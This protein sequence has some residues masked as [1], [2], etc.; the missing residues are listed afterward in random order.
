MR[1]KILIGVIILS[2]IIWGT[3]GYQATWPSQLETTP[4]A[5]WET[6]KYHK[7]GIEF[8][9]PKGLEIVATRRPAEGCDM[10][11][12]FDVLTLNYI[13]PHR[14]LA[15]IQDGIDCVGFGPFRLISNSKLPNTQ[16]EKFIGV[17]SQN[18]N[19]D[20]REFYYKIGAFTILP[21][22]NDSETEKTLDQILST[23]KYC[24]VGIC[25]QDQKAEYHY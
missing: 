6:Y 16:A 7:L 18:I 1:T 10:D 24:D 12:S 4:T 22:N 13:N 20:G 23:L 25:W 14:E 11:N 3:L 19:N 15:T 9:Y 17:N 21:K 5:G 8:M 2:G